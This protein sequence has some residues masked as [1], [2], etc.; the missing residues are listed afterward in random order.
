MSVRR[1]AAHTAGLIAVVGLTELAYIVWDGCTD[2]LARGDVLVVLGNEV[3]ASGKPHPRLA[4]R[5]EAARAC[6][7]SGCAPR[8]V[9]SGG[10]GGSG[11]AEAA[12]MRDHLVALGVP[13]SAIEMDLAGYTTRDT[14]RNV[15]RLMRAHGWQRAIVATQ[16]FHVTRSKLALRQA[17]IGD[18][19]SVR[20]HY[21]EWRDVYS[22]AREMIAIW[23]YL[24]RVK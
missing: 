22:L 12:V 4:A 21:S 1:R 14:A 2:D 23:F 15:A 7:A 3:L 18:V 24:G 11:Y 10:R 8:V 6:F 16:Y 5:L 19:G 20:A 9:V 13:G 17:G